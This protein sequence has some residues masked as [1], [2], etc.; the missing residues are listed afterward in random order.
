MATTKEIIERIA[1]EVGFMP[2]KY[3][4]AAEKMDLCIHK[5]TDHFGIKF[6]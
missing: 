6:N 2:D 3:Y 1:S 5:D 4:T